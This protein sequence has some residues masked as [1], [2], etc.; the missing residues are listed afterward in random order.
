[1]QSSSLIEV[2]L[3]LVI[4][5]MVF[6][7]AITIYLNVQ[8]SNTS[9]RKLSCETKMDEV[10]NASSQ[11]GVFGEREVNF[12]DYVIYQSVEKPDSLPN[13]QIVRLETRDMDGK[14]LAEQKHLVYV[15][16]IA[17]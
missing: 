15:P 10:F 8:K 1:M 17:P 16:E 14:L 5:A 13:L 9:S 7:L 4:T 11:A 6:G 3:A 2:T 12:S